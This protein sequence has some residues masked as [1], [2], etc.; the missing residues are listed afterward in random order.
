MRVKLSYSVEADDVL[1]EAAKIIGLVG[2]DM[3]KGISLFTETQQELQGNKDDRGIP[4][5]TK[6]LEMIEDFR[7]ALLNVDTRLSEVMEIV[8][9]YD[10]YLK[11]KDLPS[12]PPEEEPLPRLGDE[13]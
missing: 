4:N 13:E 9:G 1:S 6:A 8:K 3:Q 5:M 2:E 11:Q 7:A 10:Y 12:A